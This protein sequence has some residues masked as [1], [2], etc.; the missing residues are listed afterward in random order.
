MLEL[1]PVSQGVILH[2]LC[3]TALVSG[4]CVFLLQLSPVPLGF[5]LQAKALCNWEVYG[6]VTYKMLKLL[7]ENKEK[8]L[9]DIGFGNDF[10]D[11]TPQ[12][13]AA[14]AKMDSLDSIKLQKCHSSKDITNKVKRQ[15]AE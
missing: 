2:P 3:C 9:H 13:Q 8:G 5:S 7:E 11:I 4:P 10:L 14:K 6:L 15:P 12:A 1:V